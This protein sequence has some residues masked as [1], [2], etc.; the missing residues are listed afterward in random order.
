MTWSHAPI[1][2]AGKN[3]FH[4]IVATVP[5]KL[6]EDAEAPVFHWAVVCQHADPVT[7]ISELDP[8]AFL[9]GLS[10]IL[11]EPESFEHEVSA[12]GSIQTVSARQSSGRR[13]QA[14]Q[15][16]GRDKQACRRWPSSSLLFYGCRT[17]LEYRGYFSWLFR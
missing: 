8:P 16:D 13:S 10:V 15:A 3:P 9:F 5:P 17:T 1:Y 6:Y 12:G 2:S 11:E 14:R 4:T 7:F